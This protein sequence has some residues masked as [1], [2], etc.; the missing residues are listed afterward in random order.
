MLRLTICSKPVASQ[1][2]PNVLVLAAPVTRFTLL[3]VSTPPLKSAPSVV[4]APTPSVMEGMK[5]V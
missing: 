4:S 3:P 1:E 2:Q 5:R